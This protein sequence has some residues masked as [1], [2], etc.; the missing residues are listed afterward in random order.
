M[1]EV[2][3]FQLPNDAVGMLMCPMPHGVLQRSSYTWSSLCKELGIKYHHN[4]HRA[5]MEA[6][7]KLHVA[8]SHE[9]PYRKDRLVS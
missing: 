7:P 4:P 2:K 5:L 1:V 3:T 9:C 8:I 6:E